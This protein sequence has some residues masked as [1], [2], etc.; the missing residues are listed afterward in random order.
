MATARNTKRMHNARLST[1]RPRKI[2]RESLTKRP[3]H[4][5]PAITLDRIQ[6]YGS[7][8]GGPPKGE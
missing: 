2:P 5:P 7:D 4:G 3:K 1:C 6:S 8:G